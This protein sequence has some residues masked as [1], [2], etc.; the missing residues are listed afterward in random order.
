MFIIQFILFIQKKSLELSP[1]DIGSSSGIAR[2]FP[3]APVLQNS[4]IFND[5]EIKNKKYIYQSI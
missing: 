1:L 2:V 5:Q 4:L 3:L